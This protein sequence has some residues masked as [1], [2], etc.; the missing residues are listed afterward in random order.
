MHI[1]AQAFDLALELTV[2]VSLV[3]LLWMLFNDRRR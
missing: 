1:A 3:G 2:L